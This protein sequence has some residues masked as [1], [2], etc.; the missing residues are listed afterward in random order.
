MV[1]QCLNKN[2]KEG[3]AWG[4]YCVFQATSNDELSSI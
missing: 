2:K 1:K 4:T 3:G